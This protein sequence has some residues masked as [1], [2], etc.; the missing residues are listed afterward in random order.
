MNLEKRIEK[1]EQYT[2]TGG[3]QVLMWITYNG[4]DTKPTEAQEE[5]AIADFKDKNPGWEKQAYIL[6]EWEDG[7]FKPAETMFNGGK[8]LKTTGQPPYDFT[9]VIGKGY[10]DNEKAK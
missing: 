8:T 5:A 6:I 3:Q 9:F 4:D 1:L 10:Q 7:H 2:G